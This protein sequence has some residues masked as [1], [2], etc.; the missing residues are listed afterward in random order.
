MQLVCIKIFIKKKST[1]RKCGER[2]TNQ[3]EDDTN[4]VPPP[5]M[6]GK[7]HGSQKSRGKRSIS[8]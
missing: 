8:A 2:Y 3:K 4:E 6:R 7:A 5:H 1:P